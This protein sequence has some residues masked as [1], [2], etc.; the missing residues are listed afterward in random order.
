MPDS[1]NVAKLRCN[2]ATQ[3]EWALRTNQPAERLLNATQDVHGGTKL[4]S[5]ERASHTSELSKPRVLRE[6]A[7]E[8]MRL[9]KAA[10]LSYRR[11]RK[12]LK[13][14]DA[15]TTVGRILSSRSLPGKWSNLQK[16]DVESALAA[17]GDCCTS[18]ALP[19]GVG[20]AAKHVVEFLTSVTGREL[21]DLTQ[22]RDM[23]LTDWEFDHGVL[24]NVLR[25]LGNSG[26]WIETWLDAGTPYNVAS[27]RYYRNFYSLLALRAVAAARRF[28]KNLWASRRQWER[29]GYRVLDGEKGAPVFHY[30]SAPETDEDRTE[31]PVADQRAQGPLR[32]VS[33]VF[34]AG[35]VRRTADNRRFRLKKLVENRGDV[36]ECV[37]RH[38]AKVVHK[39]VE[40]P[41]YNPDADV[42]TMPPKRWFRARGKDD[43][44]TV[45]YYATLLHELV[46][47]TGHESRLARV[48]GENDDADYQ[49]E[50]LVAELGSGFLCARFGLGNA[51][52]MTADRHGLVAYINNWLDEERDP[53]DLLLDAAGLANRASNYL[54]YEGDETV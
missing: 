3:M 53:V 23:D 41:F 26:E 15:K 39:S 50:E 1:D 42:I 8:L 33:I 18:L 30:F 25:K 45:D 12:R 19:K 10:D 44:A 36:E 43:Q 31:R 20:R 17:F 35:Q 37:T 16:S 14:R 13:G 24:R 9:E 7:A 51:R 4:R 47:W 40:Y 54:L 49:F 5:V 6:V 38:G 48:F 29:K 34:N 28:R 21:S 46:H 2:M 52:R 32:R 27:E 11:I 22:L